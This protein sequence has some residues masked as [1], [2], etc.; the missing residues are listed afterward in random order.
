[1][2]E[3][4]EALLHQ[5]CCMFLNLNLCALFWARVWHG[6]VYASDSL[7]YAVFDPAYLVA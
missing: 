1:M 5:D 3:V 2:F 7:N 4:N 6:T